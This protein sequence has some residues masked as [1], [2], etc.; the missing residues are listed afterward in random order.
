MNPSSIDSP[1]PKLE[2]RGPGASAVIVQRVSADKEERFMAL[3]RGIVQAAQGFAGYQKVDVYPPSKREHTEWVVV[4]HF[5]GPE[6]MQRWLDSSV[7]AEWI[8]KFHSEIGES[9]LQKLP[10][11]FGAWFTGRINDTGEALPPSW[12]MA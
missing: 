1:G 3:Q 11:G 10:S 5:D 8:A 4:I 12:K 2:V 6:A 9:H 7:R